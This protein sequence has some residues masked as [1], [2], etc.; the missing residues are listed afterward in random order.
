MHELIESLHHCSKSRIV[1]AFLQYLGARTLQGKPTPNTLCQN[2]Q[3]RSSWGALFPA[4]AQQPPDWEQQGF[5]SEA[6]DNDF[7]HFNTWLHFT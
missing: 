3:R 1:A 2:R 5:G 7:Q 6:C 4:V